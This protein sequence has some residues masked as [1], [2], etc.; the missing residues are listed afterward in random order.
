[1]E[2]RQVVYEPINHTA[3]IGFRI[4]GKSLEELFEGAAFA[5]FDIL[6]D[7]DKVQ[8]KITNRIR[9]EGFDPPELLVSWLNELLFRWETQ[10]IL[11]KKFRIVKLNSS[12]LEALAWGDPFEEGRH[13]IFT[14][15]K[16][17]TYHNLQI[18][19]K[20]GIYT[21]GIILDI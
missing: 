12:V 17:A 8:G 13:E 4:R 11:Y 7:L 20:D 10:R 21:A 18:R 15:I 14:D 16:A 19:E 6:A 1:M 2:A 3:D 9:V 5:L